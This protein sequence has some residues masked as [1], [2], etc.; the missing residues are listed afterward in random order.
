VIAKYLVCGADSNFETPALFET[1]VAAAAHARSLQIH[2]DVKVYKV[3]ELM[4][5]KRRT[6]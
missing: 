1:E 4:H 2:S 6:R 3:T 5:F